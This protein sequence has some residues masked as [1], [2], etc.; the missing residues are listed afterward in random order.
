MCSI[1]YTQT[2]TILEV[3]NTF[4]IDDYSQ[5][6]IHEVICNISDARKILKFI[7]PKRLTIRC[8]ADAEEFDEVNSLNHDNILV[9]ELLF[10]PD[11]EL[12][13]VNENIIYT[14]SHKFILCH[15]KKISTSFQPTDEYL[16]ATYLRLSVRPKYINELCE[17]IETNLTLQK[18][19]LSCWIGLS[20]SDEKCIISAIN[21]TKIP[22]IKVLTS[23]PSCYENN[24]DFKNTMIV[25]D[26]RD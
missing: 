2:K 21:N 15:A 8:I 17:F 1:H 19:T 12:L 11:D 18:L 6:E 25:I 7:I 20:K 26:C 23:R 24:A 10:A 16:N 9:E 4:T 13:F 22:L 5:R 3:D 14:G